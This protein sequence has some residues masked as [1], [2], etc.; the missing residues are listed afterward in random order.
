MRLD[1][2]NRGYDRQTHCA[3][4]WILSQRAWR[5]ETGSDDVS[6]SAAWPWV[7][8]TYSWVEPTALFLLALRAAGQAEHPRVHQAE[9]M[10]LDRR[11]STG[12]WNYGNKIVLDRELRPHLQ[13]TALALLA[14]GRHRVAP[15]DLAQSLR[16]L[17]AGL[18][19][20]TATSS[21]C[22]GL[23]AL[24]AH[25]QWPGEADS[26]LAGAFDRVLRSD[27]S[28]LKLALIA[29]ACQREQSLLVAQLP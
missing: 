5:D 22:W 14:L 19:A 10:L 7:D 8:G 1:G 26:W 21:L 2:A 20:R 23:I 11:L 28:P 15:A 24:A 6:A 25:G 29:L 27:R 4:A 12:G 16:F 3:V 17:R 18:N 9:Q 13:P